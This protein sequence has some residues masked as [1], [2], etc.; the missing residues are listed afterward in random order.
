[1]LYQYRRLPKARES[2]VAQSCPT[3]C[4]PIDC[5]LPGSSIHGILQVR[6][7]EW[8]AIALFRDLPDPGRSQSLA[9]LKNP[10]WFPR[11]KITEPLGSSLSIS[12]P[13]STSIPST[14]AAPKGVT[15]HPQPRPF[16]PY[17]LLFLLTMG[18]LP[19]QGL[20]DLLKATS[21]THGH[22][23][24]CWILSFV[25]DADPA[26]TLAPEV[27]LILGSIFLGWKKKGVYFGG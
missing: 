27:N 1:M 9:L 14:S 2:E 4:D 3:L 26:L 23:S 18:I 6:V 20:L 17:A 8:G 24:L 15:R 5:S 11:K 25:P 19:E 22:H 7:L 13:G 10:Q 16:Q 12:W 21:F